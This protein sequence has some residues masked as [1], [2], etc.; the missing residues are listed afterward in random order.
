[1]AAVPDEA[2]LV[3]REREVTALGAL[4][5]SALAG[6]GRVAL[7]EGP[8][9]IGK[10]RLLQLA[11]R[12][13]EADGALVLT[14]RSSELEREFP[15]GV[16]R[17]LF[18]AELADAALRERAL[19]GAAAAARPVFASLE[20]E[21]AADGTDAS[22]ATL[23]GLFWLMLNL[24]ADRPLVLAVDDL[25]WCDRPSLRFLAYLVRRLEGL[26]VLVVC[27]RRPTQPGEDPAQVAEIAGDPLAATL[28]PAPLSEHAVRDLVRERL[29]EGSDDVFSNACHA[30][31]G[32]NP[33]LLQ[34]LLKTLDGERVSPDA[35]HVGGGR[36]SGS[37]CG[38][39]RRSIA[40]RTSPPGR[41]EHG[42]GNRRARRRRG[43]LRR[44]DARR[45]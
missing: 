8:A 44:R 16:V 24:A 29:G 31:S 18:E 43:A 7:I 11:R 12:R 6:D 30:A 25:H 2:D 15:Y 38:I 34:E 40:A 10:S 13:G 22:F 21:P 33:L 32:G 39:A 36:R 42:A 19:A 14:A 1:M 9:G 3:E 4:L 41:S 35:A 17:Q 28:H 26:P 45:P 37:A 5:D 23:H 27:S 20:P